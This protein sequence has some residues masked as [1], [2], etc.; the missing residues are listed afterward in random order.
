MGD[1][2]DKRVQTSRLAGQHVVYDCRKMKALQV[3]V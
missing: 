3:L 2:K 1:A